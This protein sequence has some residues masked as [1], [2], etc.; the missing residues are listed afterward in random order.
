[1]FETQPRVEKALLV[2]IKLMDTPDW[3]PSFSLDELESLADTAGIQTLDRCIQVRRH[4]EPATFV[5]RGKVEEIRLLSEQ[6]GAD[7]IIFDTELSPAQIKNLEKSLAKPVMDRSDIILSIFANRAR[8]REAKIQVELARLKYFMPRLKSHWSH[9]ERQVG[10]VGVR[11][12]PGEKQ[13]EV[14][15][16]I[17]RHKIDKLESELKI[18][19]KQRTI[20]NRNRQDVF[21][22]ALIGYTNVGKSSLFNRLTEAGVLVE[23]RLFAT[24]DST[25]RKISIDK[26]PLLLTDTVGFIRKLPHH[27]VASF[28][29]TLGEACDADLLLHVVDISSP[30]L[31]EQMQAV[32]EV[33]E[34]LNIDSNKIVYVLNKIDQ[35][36]EDA[37]DHHVWD[38]IP[39][40]A[41][42]VSV[43]AHTGENLDVLKELI[44]E[45]LTQDFMEDTFVF[46]AEQSRVLAQLHEIGSLVSQEYLSGNR[47]KVVCRAAKADLTRL[48]KQL[49]QAQPSEAPTAISS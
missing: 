32:Q 3:E 1:M 15:R 34:Q 8:T 18:I 36:P 27:L 26:H 40:D 13:I 21:T 31:A 48:K 25:V 2:G 28:R 33:L 42:Y 9:L 35:L 20:R 43:S 4:V 37:Q 22:V 46:P 7:V 41:P 44:L 45:T 6:L 12:G 29:S 47:L 38:L 14:D 10:G 30:V 17:I 5:G 16:R 24:L 11:G 49:R 23:D 39:E 19:E